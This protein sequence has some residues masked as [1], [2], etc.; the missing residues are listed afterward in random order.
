[1]RLKAQMRLAAIA[2]AGLLLLSTC[3]APPCSASCAGCCDASGACQAGTTA[4]ACGLGGK[5]CAPCSGTDRCSASSGACGPC[6]SANCSGCC[7]SDG[8][9][10]VEVRDR[11]A[12]CGFNGAACVDCTATGKTCSTS[13]LACQ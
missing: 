2:L 8:R 11:N 5:L 9:C 13:A 1:V 4:D 3:G 7:T 6:G 10:V 12:N